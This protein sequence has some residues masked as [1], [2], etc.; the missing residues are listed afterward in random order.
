[1]AG[2]YRVSGELSP[3]QMISLAQLIGAIAGIASG[4]L[5]YLLA[6]QIS[7]SH[8]A[9]LL[10]LGTFCFSPQ[11]IK[12]NING[13]ETSLTILAV[14]VIFYMFVLF[15][16]KAI[17]SGQV[18]VAGL[19]SGFA[20][21]ARVDVMLVVA[22][23]VLFL[24]IVELTKPSPRWPIEIPKKLVL[25]GFACLLPLLPWLWFSVS[26]GGGLVPESGTAV[27]L[28]SQISNHLPLVSTAKAVLFYP[29]MFIPYYISNAVEFTSAWARQVP[30]LLPMTI[31]LYAVLGVKSAPAISC[32]LVIA[33]IL[34]LFRATS[35]TSD[36]VLFFVFS[37]WL[38]YMLAMTLAYSV[39]IQGQWFYD[40]YAAPVG[41]LLNI[42]IIAVLIQC[43]MTGMNERYKTGTVLVGSLMIG[44][45]FGALLL[46]GSYRWLVFGQSAVPDDGFYRTSL[47][48]S[49]S[50]PHDTRV[51]VFQA[52]LIGYY[53]SQHVIPL[54]GK[55]NSDARRAIAGGY[56]F[57][58]LCQSGISYVADW[59]SQ[60]D[61]LLIERSSQWN[62]GNL[63][64]IHVVVAPEF[65]DI[66]IYEVNK[67]AC[68]QARLGSYISVRQRWQK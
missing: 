3:A 15:L 14:L 59:Y 55:V 45:S 10:T 40:R 48:L 47:Y 65:N 5:V 58:Y 29:G 23:L 54:D 39:I 35:Q 9:A 50:L 26:V 32:V 11:I 52:G 16:N 20:I 37:I 12:Y 38:F 24:V 53:A 2:I 62:S 7:K 63:H 21:L 44:L 18:F 57:D 56:M 64:L 61:A 28:I 67:K 36:R 4:Y 19:V 41:V 68:G 31:P 49:E 42:L 34:F 22:L 6:L 1:M 46:G 8:V 25:F 33:L 43:G 30:V 66:Y 60:I 51:G 27:G 17:S 13:M